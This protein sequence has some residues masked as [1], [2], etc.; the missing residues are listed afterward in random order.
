MFVVTCSEWAPFLQKVFYYT[1]E[2][3]PDRL[4]RVIHRERCADSSE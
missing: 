2:K 1:Q 4:E 3:S